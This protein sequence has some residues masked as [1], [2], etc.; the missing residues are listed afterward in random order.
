MERIGEPVAVAAGE[1]RTFLSADGDVTV[2]LS[3]EST[4]GTVAVYE[5]SRTA[6][7]SRDAPMHSHPGFDEVFY[8]LAGEY[9]FRIGGRVVHA[10]EGWVLFVPRGAFH[11]F[12]G[13]GRLLAACVPGGIEELLDGSR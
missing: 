10:T 2:R 13:T 6:G 11:G 5:S 7:D 8:V 1:G 3:D 12:R 9:E 4:G